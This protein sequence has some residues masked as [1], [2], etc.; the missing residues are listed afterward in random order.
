MPLMLMAADT[1]IAA[2]IAI[3]AIAEATPYFRL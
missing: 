1:D 3:D 2:I